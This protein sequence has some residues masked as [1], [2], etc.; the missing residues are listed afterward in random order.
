MREVT[1]RLGWR[2]KVYIPAVMAIAAVYL[3]PPRLLQFFTGGVAA[4]SEISAERFLILLVVFGLGVALCLWLAAF[5]SNIAGEWLRL[6]VSIGLRRDAV[7]A[8]HR[9]RIEVLDTAHRGDW[10]TR[11]TSDLRNCEGF[12]TDSIPQQIQN[13]TLALGAATLFFMA[14]GWIAFIPIGAALLLAILN[15]RVQRK[16]APVLRESRE[17]EGE[18]F[19]AM[20]E[21][22]EGVRT[23][24]SSGSE[25]T[26]LVR[27]DRQFRALFAA[28]MKIIRSMGALMAIN[29]FAS[30][31]VVTVCLT[32][33]VMVLQGG[34]LTVVAV[35]VF[36][37][38][39]N[40]F[41]RNVGELAAGAYDWN[42]FFV[43]GG[44]LAA[45]LYDEDACV[46]EEKTELIPERLQE[47]VVQDLELGYGG[48]ESILTGF[49]FSIG[50]GEIVALMGPSGSGKST[51]LEC[52]AGLRTPRAGSFVLRGWSNAVVM[53]EMPVTTTTL[54]EQRPYLFV[55]TVRENLLL[56][57]EAVGDDQIWAVLED[58]RMAEV[59][60][61]RGGLDAELLDRGLN[62]SEGQRYRLSLA[63]AL[64][65][66]RSL[67]LLDE[68][69]AALDEDSVSFVVRALKAEKSKGR[70]V[71]MATHILPRSLEVD[72]AL[73]LG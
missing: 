36:P 15:A 38:F 60:R 42:R 44:R 46:Q 23:I 7:Q 10:M 4:L 43:E 16:M 48:E 20:M 49:S 62:M 52:L 6:T 65:S 24:R 14:A 63:R 55:G 28:G 54:V 41:L 26:T 70:A 33:V 71:I 56:G 5:L 11:M 22:Y 30:Q 25:A 67:L 73:R 61:D 69:F 8:L 18:I 29:E 3:L 66:P 19:Q 53:D 50:V 27:I 39:I 12:L 13:V 45:V 59:I 34:E 31:V 21:S 40:V 32:V 17:I 1:R 2:Y 57:S 35:L 47:V 64:L 68:P 37:F 72:R 51:L 9:T 58:L